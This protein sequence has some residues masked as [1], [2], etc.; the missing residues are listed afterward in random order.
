MSLKSLCAHGD[1]GGV[2]ILFKSWARDSSTEGS[3]EA[4]KAVRATRC[5]RYWKLTNRHKTPLTSRLWSW[6][7]TT[8]LTA[9]CVARS[10]NEASTR[11]VKFHRRRNKSFTIYELKEVGR[12]VWCTFVERMWLDFVVYCRV[13]P[14]TEID[15]K[16]GL[17]MM[18]DLTYLI[19]AVQFTPLDAYWDYLLIPLMTSPRNK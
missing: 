13:N 16:C 4:R 9:D 18:M 14:M 7:S 5:T 1:I 3:E 6:Q 17:E 2:N 12:D 10:E 19:P 8:N 15:Y 11:R